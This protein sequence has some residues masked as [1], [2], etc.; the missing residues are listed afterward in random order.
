MTGL[1]RKI[2]VVKG[3]PLLQTGSSDGI[4]LSKVGG[5]D[6]HTPGFI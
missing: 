4:V 3:N 2:E 6:L 5:L 1:K